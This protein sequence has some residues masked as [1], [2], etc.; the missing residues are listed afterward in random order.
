MNWQLLF[1]GLIALGTIAVAVL[2]IWGDWFKHRLAGPDLSL[3]AHN[4]RGNATWI[5]FNVGQ[6]EESG[7]AFRAI[8][9]HLKVVNKRR[10]V[11]VRNCRVLLLALHRKGPD[12]Y[13]HKIP[14]VVQLQYIWTPAEFAPILQSFNKEAILD[15]GKLM[16]GQKVFQP[17]LYVIP[18]NFNGFIGANE[19]VR[20]TLQVTADN[21]SGDIEHVF[22]V[23][24]NG[25]FSD[26][27]DDMERNLIIKE[28]RD[29]L[30]TG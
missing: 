5:R 12:G 24:W 28:V 18:N 11:T 6:G 17:T 20:Y 19:S 9:Y 3:V 1:D 21:Y 29:N 10:W 8:F 14:L 16:E 30:T 15:F 2:A 27:M 4:F 7:N 25:Q 26:N 23:S 22:E 13:F